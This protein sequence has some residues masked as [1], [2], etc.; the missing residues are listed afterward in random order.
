ME[1]KRSAEEADFCF[2]KAISNCRKNVEMTI[3]AYLGDSWQIGNLGLFRL[4]YIK[5]RFSTFFFRKRKWR[6]KTLALLAR[7][8]TARSLAKIFIPLRSKEK[9]FNAHFAAD[10]Y[11]RAT[12]S[13]MREMP[14]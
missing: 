8:Q 1:S 9:F 2:Y 7:R 4:F 13:A 5:F 14:I 3:L 12:Q 10:L 11:R 6:K